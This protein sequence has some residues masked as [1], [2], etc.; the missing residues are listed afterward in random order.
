MAQIRRMDCQIEVKSSADK[1]FDA[2]KTKAHLMPKMS[3][4]LVSDIKLLEGDWTSVGS[5]RL[6][7]YSANN[8]C[9]GDGKVKV[10][11]IGIARFEVGVKLDS[12][13]TFETAKELRESV[14]EENRT[15]VYKLL[16]GE[17]GNSYKNWR[18]I[19]SVTPMGEGSLVKWTFEY[20]KLN[21]DVPEPVKYCD[22]HTTWSKDVDAYLLN[23]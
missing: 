10:K 2:F 14:D 22:F 15:I 18:S 16:E 9:W 12:L 8:K 17:I 3:S 20:E 1:F 7:Y 13:N 6:W 21:D 19:L 11:P 4:Q 5:V 23:S